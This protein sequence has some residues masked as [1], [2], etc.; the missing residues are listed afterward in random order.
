[1]SAFTEPSSIVLI[2]GAICIFIFIIH[3]LWFSGKPQ[4]RKLQKDN[5]RDQEIR[6]SNQV[7]KVRIVTSELPAEDESELDLDINIG[8]ISKASPATPA[9]NRH[10]SLPE[11]FDDGYDA[12]QNSASVSVNQQPRLSQDPNVVV[13]E[14]NYEGKEEPQLQQGNYPQEQAALNEP[15][16]VYELI[17]SAVPG[18]PYL[19]EDIEDICN[20]KGFIQGF[21]KDKLKIYF[22]YEN[23][24]TKENEVFRICSM[25]APY[26]FPDDMKGFQTSAIALYMTLPERGKAFAYFKALRMATEIFIDQLGGQIQDQHRNPLSPEQLDM[27]AAELQHYDGGLNSI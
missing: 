25:E 10:M 27:I 14:I 1:M 23:S 19:G 17:V 3:G 8:K 20:Q 9:N 11:G 6:C 7:G 24:N 2:I 16:S 12:L 5:A 18:R 21:I 15:R 22:V 13:E 4:N 26:Y